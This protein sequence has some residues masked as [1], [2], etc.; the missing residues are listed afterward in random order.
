MPLDLQKVKEFSIR[1]Q[2]DDEE[3]SVYR[4]LDAS[5]HKGLA[6]GSYTSMITLDRYTNRALYYQ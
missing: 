4:Q 5:Y 6:D 1:T 3:D 2:M